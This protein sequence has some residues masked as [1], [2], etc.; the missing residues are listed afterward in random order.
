MMRQDTFVYL[1]KFN[2]SPLL[3]YMHVA[4]GQFQ[5]KKHE[6]KSAVKIESEGINMLPLE[7]IYFLN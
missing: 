7:S 5:T 6:S 4:Q 2:D 3:R 1:V